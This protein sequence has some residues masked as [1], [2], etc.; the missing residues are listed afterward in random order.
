MRFFQ[1][2]RPRSLQ[3][4]SR[5]YPTYGLVA[6]VLVLAIAL[7]VIGIQKSRE[8]RM[9]ISARE[10]LKSSIQ[11]DLTMVMRTYDQLNLPKADISGTL[12]P[13]IRQHLYSAYAMNTVLADV[14]GNEHSILDNGFYT[15][16]MSAVDEMDS[17]IGRGIIVDVTTSALSGCI[18]EMRNNL[19]NSEGMI[20]QTA[21]K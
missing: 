13:V 11:S 19:A 2:K 9:L 16:I 20:P 21:L 14:Y 3:N 8:G 15:Q 10:Q 18:T 17:Q 5:L 12:L 6:L 1:L 7:T 4:K